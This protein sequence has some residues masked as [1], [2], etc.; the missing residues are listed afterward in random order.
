M[1]SVSHR[2]PCP[3]SSYLQQ[4][5]LPLPHQ[6]TVLGAVRGVQLSYERPFAHL[7]VG[8]LLDAHLPHLL[9]LLGRLYHAGDVHTL[10][11]Q[12]P[13]LQTRGPNSPV[14]CGS[15]CAKPWASRMCKLLPIT[16]QSQRD[17][18]TLAPA[19][20]G[21]GAAERHGWNTFPGCCWVY[22][23]HQRRRL[24][25]HQLRLHMGHS[26]VLPSQLQPPPRARQVA[27]TKVDI[28]S[29]VKPAKEAEKVREVCV[30]EASI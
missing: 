18:G 15:A 27:P 25:S 10:G 29:T 23:L 4:Q 17:G 8:R 22:V 28:P 12:P 7:N 5:L 6:H 21:G 26:L 14:P 20:E 1:A 3:R 16:L 13:S 9:R 30:Q 11:C 19:A 2:Y 24:G